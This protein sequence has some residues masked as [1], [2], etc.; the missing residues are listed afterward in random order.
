MI[1]YECE[2]CGQLVV[3]E[4]AIGQDVYLDNVRGKAFQWQAPSGEVITISLEMMWT[5]QG[6]RDKPQQF[7]YGCMF[8]TIRGL[9]KERFG[10]LAGALVE[11]CTCHYN[12]SI[13][14]VHAGHTRPF[15]GAP[16][17]EEGLVFD[18]PTDTSGESE[19]QELSQL[20]A[21][22][23]LSEPRSDFTPTSTPLRICTCVRKSSNNEITYQDP[24]C[25][26]HSPGGSSGAG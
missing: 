13:C 22:G 10:D 12:E 24:S 19:D 1:K 21:T 9:L 2:L 15:P 6:D 11:N 23:E 4:E 20:Y 14:P 3:T 17:P 8:R 7:C 25:P 16:L 18:D 5:E 26:V